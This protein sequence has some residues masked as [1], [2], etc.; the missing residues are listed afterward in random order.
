MREFDVLVVGDAN[1]DLV[2]RGDVRPRFGQQEQLLTGADL[3]LGGSAAITATGCAR[4]GLRTALLT[5][6]GDDLFG[7]IVRDQLRA[8][9][10][11]IITAPAAGVP[12]GLTVILN[13][14][15]DRA[16]LTLPGTIAA[17]RPADVTDALLGRARHVHVA[18]LYLQP[19]LAEGLAPVFARARE[20]GLTTSLDTNWDP[21]ERWDWVPEIL[22][23]TDVFLPNSAELHAITGGDGPEKLV[24]A[25]TIVVMKDGIRGARAWWPGGE[26]TAPA[27]PVEVVDAVG[28][29]DSFNAGFL[30]ACLTGRT[31][32]EAVAW[33]AAAGSLS[34]RA[35]GGTAAQPTLDDFAD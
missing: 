28:A 12:T 29:G 3:V 8:R 21:A 16:M 31:V 27:R 13:E 17:L 30:A 23:H 32:R 24:A 5:A 22:P 10:V 11:R 34:T 2:L 19:A 7:E 35:A 15:D 33:A 4:L 14:A 1:P 20:L 18:S 26:S 25:G 6:I 9:N